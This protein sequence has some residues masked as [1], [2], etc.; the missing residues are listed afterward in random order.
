MTD[1]SRI[2]RNIAVYVVGVMLLSTAGGAV[3]AR[4]NEVGGLI[5][6]ASPILVSAALRTAAGDGWENAGLRPRIRGN[7]GWYALSVLVYPATFVIVVSL[8][9]AAGLV[10]F[11]VPTGSVPGLFAAGLAVQFV[12]RM[13]F[14]V[15]EEF[16]WRGYLDPQ[17]AA[18]GLSDIHRGI[19]V[20]LAWAVW[21]VPFILTT[22][23]TD[24]PLRVFLPL[25]TV[26]VVVAALVY[27]QIRKYSG[28]V[29]PAVVM[30]GVANA[31]AW[32]IVGQDILA[33]SNRAVVSLAPESAVTIGVWSILAL[34]LLRYD[35]RRP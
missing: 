4:G 23:Y 22:E 9:A 17:L 13:L 11:N 24:V 3:L 18:L 6:I 5:F 16:G 32:A 26:G 28:S 1:Q 8:G 10:D 14:A 25:F 31:V 29:W 35:D 34:W 12:P 20:G 33:F 21:H 30:H 2:R 27:G 19:A 15:F 7:V